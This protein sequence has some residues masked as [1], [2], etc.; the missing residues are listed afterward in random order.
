M[1]MESQIQLINLDNIIPN[2]FQPRLQ[3]DEASLNELANS[4][5]EHGIIQP[6]VL[7]RVANKFEIIAGERRYKAA[8]IA[9]LTS[10]PAI[11]ADLDDNESAEVA[12]I[13]NTHRRSLS[14]I[15][16]AKSYKKLLDRRYVTQEQLAKRLGTSQS[17]VANKIR[18]LTLDESVQD[19]LL[20]DKI[21]E[22]HARSLLRVTDKYKQV[23]LLNKTINERWPVRLLDEEID[24][25]LGT[26]Q[27]GATTTGAINA[28]SRIDIDVDNVMNNSIDILSENDGE[29]VNYQYTARDTEPTKK[30]DSLFFNN[31][32]NESVNMDPTL[33]FGFNPFKNSVTTDNAVDRDIEKDYDLLELEEDEYD[34]EKDIVEETAPVEAQQVIVEEEYKTKD[35]VILGIKKVIANAKKNEVGVDIEEFNFDNFYQFIIRINDDK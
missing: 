6:L 5:R 16:E 33:N 35:D 8:T 2:R 11:I 32:E 21:S 29:P 30:R 24:K 25:V 3:F 28:N 4:I 23:D 18:L 34:E 9:G 31:L 7:R 22:R 20:K 13:E 17:N 12:I 19:A 1:K 27:K 10:V 14:P 26:Y 15:E